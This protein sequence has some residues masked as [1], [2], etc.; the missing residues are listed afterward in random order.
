MN[1][2]CG[3]VLRVDFASHECKTAAALWNL[4][5]A[6]MM[7]SVP[8]NRFNWALAGHEIDNSEEQI[9]RLNA[10]TFVFTIVSY[11]INITFRET[12]GGH[13]QQRV[14]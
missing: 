2:G 10:V 8:T 1:Q 11:P 4:E 12:L 13:N 7:L 6:E 14:V 3:L 9:R 5:S